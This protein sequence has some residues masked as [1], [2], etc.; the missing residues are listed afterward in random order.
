MATPSA[1]RDAL[2]AFLPAEASPEERVALVAAALR[3]EHGTALRAFLGE[4]IVEKAVPVRGLVPDSYRNWRP[5]VRDAMLFVI[6]HLSAE[7]LAPKLLEQVALSSTMRPERRLLRLISTVPGLQK[8]GQVLARNRN[9]RPGLRRALTALENGIHDVEARDVALIVRKELGGRVEKFDVRIA[10]RLMC[11]A[12]VSAILPFTWRNPQTGLRERGVFKVMKPHIPKFFREDMQLLQDMTRYFGS[13]LHEY[14]FATDVLSDTFGK[15]RRLLQHEIDFRGEQ[16]TLR[17]AARMYASTPGVRVPSVIAPLCTASITAISEERGVK[18]TAAATRMTAGARNRL[19]EQL[20]RALVAVPLF[21]RDDDAL[22]HADPHAGNLLYDDRRK[23]IVI[24]DWALTERLGRAQRRHLALLLLSLALRDPVAV[25]REIDGLRESR[26]SLSAR[27]RRELREFVNTY[28]DELPLS[29]L[30][31]AVDAMRLIEHLTL[32]RARFPASLVMLSKVLFT[33]DGI[34][35]DIGGTNAWLGVAVARQAV[36]R[37][38]RW[39]LGTKDWLAVNCSALL[40]P[41]RVWVK[42][43][44]KMAERVFG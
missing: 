10:P 11:E 32:R 13:R 3:G 22:F 20:V 28:V 39:P 35:A 7:R 38:A 9:L 44:E 26:S 25:W 17:S 6:N 27:Q 42:W 37:G 21:A 12:S 1:L 33:L 4:W 14:G 29:R 15:V 24:L 16:R 31:G 30:P 43:E 19:A 8:L 34:L 36:R 40:Y 18:I 41:G 5:V 2:D 23:E